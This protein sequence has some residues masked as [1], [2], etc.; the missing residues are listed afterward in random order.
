MH[1]FSTFYL[2]HAYTP[3]FITALLPFIIIASIWSLTLKGFALWYA[4]RGEQKWW[5]VG[6]LVLNTVGI[7]EIIYLVW[8]RP[9][10]PHTHK[11]HSHHTPAH[12]SSAGA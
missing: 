2:P 6:L 7:L 1:P 11:H 3:P 8:F 12:E 10:T 9:S 4:A 5:F